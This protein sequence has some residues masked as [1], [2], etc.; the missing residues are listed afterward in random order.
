MADFPFLISHLPLKNTAAEN[1][2]PLQ[3]MTMRNVK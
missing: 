1:Y 2:G 3:A